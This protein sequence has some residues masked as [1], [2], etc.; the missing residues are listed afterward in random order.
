MCI[1]L[2]VYVYCMYICSYGLVYKCIYL[3]NWPRLVSLSDTFGL[4]R[5]A[6]TH[7]CYIGQTEWLVNS[8]MSLYNCSVAL[9][10]SLNCELLGFGYESVE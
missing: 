3:S 9:I 10:A 7:I 5:A 8:T 4:L 6:H 1:D 2:N